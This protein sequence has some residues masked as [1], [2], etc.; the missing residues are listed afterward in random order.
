D[1]LFNTIYIIG[2]A[3]GAFRREVFEYVGLYS[4]H[5][6][7]EDIDLS[8]RIQE[9]GMKIVYAP[10]AVVYTEGASN[11]G[12]L[13][14]QRLRW[15]RGRFQTF[16]EHHQLF[17]SKQEHHNKLLTWGVLPLALFGDL[18]LFFEVLFLVFLYIYSFLTHDFS[19]FVSGV[20]V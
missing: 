18:Q 3:A 13:L 10:D 2:G 8:V 1:S 6:I 17:F 14:S 4:H 5:N 12:G 15:K 16:F 7:T 20:I 19:S 9:A 11:F